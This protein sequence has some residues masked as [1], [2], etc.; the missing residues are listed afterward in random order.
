MIKRLTQ[1]LV[2]HRIKK[3]V[4][5]CAFHPLCHESIVKNLLFFVPTYPYIYFFQNTYF[6]PFLSLCNRGTLIY[7]FIHLPSYVQRRLI[8]EGECNFP[9]YVNDTDFILVEWV[10][11][12]G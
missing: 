6:Y 12:K 5:L 9:P 3:A 2:L 1:P 11:L 7:A 4:P 8:W 10:F